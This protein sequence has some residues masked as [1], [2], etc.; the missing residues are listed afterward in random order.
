MKELIAMKNT[1]D[2]SYHDKSQHLEHLVEGLIVGSQ[3]LWKF[4]YYQPDETLQHYQQN[5]N[6]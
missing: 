4:N 6:N 2:V 5:W 3:F 1:I